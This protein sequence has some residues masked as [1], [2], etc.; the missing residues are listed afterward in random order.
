MYYNFL[1]L[2]EDD[3]EE[4]LDDDELG[5]EEEEVSIVELYCS[6]IL[7]TQIFTPINCTRFCMRPGILGKLIAT[8]ISLIYY[9]CY[10]HANN[11]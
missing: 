2:G 5:E 4:G 9:I 1:D 8:Y 6:M 11:E 10:V 7:C 3:D